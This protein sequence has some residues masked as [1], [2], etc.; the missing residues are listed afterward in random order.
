[1]LPA[2][3]F[4]CVTR[5]EPGKQAAVCHDRH[6]LALIDSQ[7][8][9]PEPPEFDFQKVQPQSVT[10]TLKFFI[11]ALNTAIQGKLFNVS[12]A[13]QARTRGWVFTFASS[14][15]ILIQKPRDREV[16]C[17]VNGRAIEEANWV[18]HQLSWPDSFVNFEWS[19][20]LG[21]ADGKIYGR[22]RGCQTTLNGKVRK[23]P[24]IEDEEIMR[25]NHEIHVRADELIR[26]NTTISSLTE[27]VE[28]LEADLA[29]AR[30]QH[31]ANRDASQELE[32][33][34]DAARAAWNQTNAERHMLETQ[35]DALQSQ[36]KLLEA[37]RWEALT[38]WVE[39]RG[40]RATAF[41]ALLYAAHRM[42]LR[43]RR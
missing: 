13:N 26:L 36:V 5:R 43:A 21:D 18:T 23:P 31:S 35:F 28:S 1:M 9:A 19:Y 39:S 41:L 25:K 2:L 12:P 14:P 38:R 4:V 37:Q 30:N 20:P 40:L 3:E 33:Q 6:Y 22:V 42:S 17:E 29:S 16:H 7:G 24:S 11:K 34:V 15:P 27:K 10:V 32:K 8:S